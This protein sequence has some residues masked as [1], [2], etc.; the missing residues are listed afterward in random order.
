MR[1]VVMLSSENGYRNAHRELETTEKHD[2]LKRHR[3]LN[4]FW[5]F[6]TL[7]WYTSS[8]SPLLDVRLLIYE[9][10]F[11][12]TLQCFLLSR[13]TC[14]HFDIIKYLESSWC[15]LYTKHSHLFGAIQTTP[16]AFYQARSRSCLLYTSR[17][18]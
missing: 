7:I 11:F 4:V 17:C 6:F 15:R 16:K 2:L 18:V 3:V 1:G 14:M 12:F 13:C 10:D 9:S 5:Y 8:F